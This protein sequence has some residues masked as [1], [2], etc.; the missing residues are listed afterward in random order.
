MFHS[1]G[2]NKRMNKIHEKSPRL[3]YNDNI[4]SFVELPVKDNC[5]TIHDGNLQ[6]SAIEIF[7]AIHDLNPT[8]TKNVFQVKRTTYNF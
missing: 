4:S 2:L 7:K 6:V 3:V 5:V 8:I 1:R